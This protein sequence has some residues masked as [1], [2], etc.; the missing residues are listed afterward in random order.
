MYFPPF[1]IETRYR[2][3]DRDEFLP[4][5]PRFPRIQRYIYEPSRSVFAV[6]IDAVIG[7]ILNGAASAWFKRA[8]RLK[9]E[10]GAR[11]GCNCY[12]PVSVIN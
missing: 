3:D 5:L 10:N 1:R 2:R 9:F 12:I 4:L 7:L 6:V 11:L 8:F